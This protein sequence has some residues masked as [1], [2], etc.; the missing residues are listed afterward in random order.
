MHEKIIKDKIRNMAQN[1]KCNCGSNY[2]EIVIG[3]A[4]YYRCRL[5]GA[6]YSDNALKTINK[7]R[8]NYEL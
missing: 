1:M 7:L 8:G 4:V 3:E 6:R 5:C 2:P